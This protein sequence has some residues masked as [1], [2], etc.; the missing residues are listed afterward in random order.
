[1]TE[2]LQTMARGRGMTDGQM[3][4]KGG[5]K[6]NPL[7]MG[8]R[9]NVMVYWRGQMDHDPDRFCMARVLAG[10]I[11]RLVGTCCGASNC[12]IAGTI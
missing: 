4:L 5:Q 1:M 7:C 6:G 9:M 2:G 12:T 8:C 10:H 3:K 11:H